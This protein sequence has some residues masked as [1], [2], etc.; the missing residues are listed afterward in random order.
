MKKMKQVSKEHYKFDHYIDPYRWLS[1]RE[2]IKNTLQL[3]P[4]NILEIGVGT[5]VYHT[6]IQHFGISVKTLD[7]DKDLYPDY[8]SSV[9]D[10]PIDDKKFDICVCFQ[11]LEHLTF[12]DFSRS[13]KEMKRVSK[14]YII[15][16]LPDRKRT[17]PIMLKL[18]HFGIKAFYIELPM[19]L[20]K[21]FS[22]DGEHYWEIN[23]KGYPLSRINK[24]FEDLNL[25][26]INNYRIKENPY[27]RMFVLKINE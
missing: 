15:M 26:I 18:P 21:K 7:Y 5:G 16:T 20:T 24:V 12:S 3:S 2:Q 11:V 9:T 23:S 17:I 13:L 10:I 25:T 6:L 19:F 4:E 22:F 27:H 8:V 1:F 14:R